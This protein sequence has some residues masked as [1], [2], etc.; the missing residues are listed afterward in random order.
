MRPRYPSGANGLSEKAVMNSSCSR[1]RPAAAGRKKAKIGSETF[2][3]RRENFLHQAGLNASSGLELSRELGGNAGVKP[4]YTNHFTA[5]ICALSHRPEL[6]TCHD[7]SSSLQDGPC[8]G[9]APGN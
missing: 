5:P 3:D 9:C 1:S 7:R 2:K 4:P 8:Q 6:R